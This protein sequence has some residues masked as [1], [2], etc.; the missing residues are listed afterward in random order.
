MFVTIYRSCQDWC[1]VSVAFSGWCW[2]PW[3]SWSCKYNIVV[4]AHLP[5]CNM[6]F[7]SHCFIHALSS[8]TQNPFDSATTKEMII[9]QHVLVSAS[10]L[11][12]NLPIMYQCSACILPLKMWQGKSNSS[13]LFTSKMVAYHLISIL[14]LLVS[15][16]LGNFFFKPSCV[17]TEDH[18]LIRST[19]HVHPLRSQAC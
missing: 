17:Q 3:S 15:A 7:M 8:G 12:A 2:P 4:E 10:D 11:K 9:A 16:V 18:F 1:F 19:K 13:A 5:E 6:L 14:C